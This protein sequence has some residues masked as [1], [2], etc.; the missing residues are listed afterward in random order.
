MR[1]LNPSEKPA[2]RK[3]DD[4]LGIWRAILLCIAFDVLLGALFL[5]W[6]AVPWLH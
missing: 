2:Q 4:G 1:G 6:R 5:I 3:V